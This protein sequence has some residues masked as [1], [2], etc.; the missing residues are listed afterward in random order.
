MRKFIVE[1]KIDGLGR[2]SADSLHN[3]VEASNNVLNGMDK[4]YHWVQSYVT[5]DTLF[6]VH[7][8]PD[9]E[10]VR[11]HAA[12]GGFPADRIMEVKSVIDAT[13]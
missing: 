9:E 6:C 4:P 7:V 8:A 5:D 2:L 13:S 1:R 12:R 3:M 10:S 11:E